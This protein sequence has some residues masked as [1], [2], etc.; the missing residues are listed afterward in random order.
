MNPILIFLLFSLAH[1]TPKVIRGGTA[2]NAAAPGSTI[3]LSAVLRIAT[4]TIRA[5]GT[6]IAGFGWSVPPREHS[7]LARVGR[8]DSIE[9]ALGSPDLLPVI[10][11]LD[12]GFWILD[13]ALVGG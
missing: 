6:T 9:R 11:I 7:L 10:W 8:R 2:T 4:G 3:L 5:I 12:F 13:V 1:S